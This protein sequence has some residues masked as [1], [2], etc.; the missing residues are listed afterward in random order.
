M[1]SFPYTT[2]GRPI[3]RVI[4]RIFIQYACPQPLVDQSAHHS[5]FDLLIKK[6]I[7]YMVIDIIKEL[8][9]ICIVNTAHLTIKTALP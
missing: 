1:E 2:L 4:Q 8:A 9:D 7:Q 5:V 3:G 6:A